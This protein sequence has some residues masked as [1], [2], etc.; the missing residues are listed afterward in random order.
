L[1][2]AAK[3]IESQVD[4]IDLNLGC[5]EN[6]ARK[7]DYGAFLL[8]KPE[9][10]VTAISTMVESLAVPVTCKIRLMEKGHHIP[11]SQRGL[12][13]TIAFCQRLENAGCGM[14][15]VHGRDRHNKGQKIRDADWDA[16]K[17]IKSCTR[18]PVVANGNIALHSDVD[19]C[20]KFTNCDGVMS[21]EALL[22]DPSLFSSSD[23]E[24]ITSLALEY[25]DLADAYPPHSFL[26]STKIH[27]YRMLYGYLQKDLGA[28]ELLRQAADNNACRSVIMGLMLFEKSLDPAARLNLKR[29]WYKRHRSRQ[30]AALDWEGTTQ[31]LRAERKMRMRKW[32]DTGTKMI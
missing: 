9:L 22:S 30:Q 29:A 24:S 12:A 7:R 32:M 13:G 31:Q 16:I 19:Q 2:A 26:R 1:V 10:V 21:A 6:V 4:A 17:Q 23:D 8:R 11:E 15:C 3:L 20:L 28:E 25:L 14:I 5:P 18:L 27:L